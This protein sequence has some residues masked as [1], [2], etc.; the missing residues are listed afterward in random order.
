M[1][2]KWYTIDDDFN[3]PDTITSWYDDTFESHISIIG[4]PPTLPRVLEA[5]GNQYYFQ[6]GKIKRI[7]K[8]KKRA[9]YIVNTICDR[10]KLNE[11]K[12]DANL[13]D[14][15]QETQLA[16]AKLLGREE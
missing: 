11:D 4:L 3:L 7:K 12:I 9:S 1:W 15:S 8:W 16:I 6:D 13:R 14:Q 2:L 10:K 5:F